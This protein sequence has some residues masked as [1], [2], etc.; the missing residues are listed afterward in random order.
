[1][2]ELTF[3]Q[4]QIFLL[5]LTVGL[6]FLGLFWADGMLQVSGVMVGIIAFLITGIKDMNDE[7]AVK[8]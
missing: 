7:E 6:V 5:V 1:M 8:E 4:L 2:T 3:P